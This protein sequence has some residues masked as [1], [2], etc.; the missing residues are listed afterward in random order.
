MAFYNISC[1]SKTHVPLVRNDVVASLAYLGKSDDLECKKYSIMTL[2]NLAANVETR[3]A[4]SRNGG[5]QTAIH[6]IKDADLDCRRYA[7]IALCN[8]ANNTTT[9]EQIVVHGALPGLLVM[10]QDASDIESQRQALLTISNLASNEMNHSSLMGKK[11][12]KV[13]TDAFESPDADVREYAAFAIANIAANPDYTALVG[14]N[15]GIPPL[16][17]LSKSASINTVCLG[18]AALRRMADS[19]E[20]WPKLIQAGMLDS[21]ANSGGST[22]LEIV[23]EVAAALCSLSLSHPHRV[24]IAYK[25]IR[26]MIQL[27]TSNNLDVARQSVGALANLAEDVDT[28]EYIARAGGSSCLVS[29]ERHESIDIHREA[30]RGIAN[31]LSSFRHQATIIEDGVPGLVR[32]AFS[33]DQ[34]CCYHSAMSFRKLAPNL[35]SHPVLVYA[36]TYKALFHLLTLPHQNTQRQAAAALRDLAANPEYKLRCAEDGG[37]PAMVDLV[38]QQADEEL[39][40]LGLAALRHISMEDSLKKMIVQERALRPSLKAIT[41]NNE[42]IQLQCA[43]LLANLSEL[44]ENQ[45]PM[46]E[47]SAVVGLVTLAFSKNPEIQQDTAR[48]L[49]NLASQQDAHV[50][51]YKQGA[52]T[53]LVKLSES[54]L[55]I[56]QRY[57]SIG[58][59]FLST[60]TEVISNLPIMLLYNISSQLHW[61]TGSSDACCSSEDGT[62]YLAK[63]VVFTGLPSYGSSIIR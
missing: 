38:R 10:A 1:A 23:R 39:Q 48:A 13:L 16:I 47:D 46:V 34:E 6:M 17:Q 60:D 57:A 24:E 51:M 3:A 43:G 12:M 63:R 49:A 55:D 41:S 54:D 11:I 37:I 20:N 22:E 5:L 58:I 36:G 44:A 30:S 62:I 40:A 61:T 25:C 7:C 35:K 19:E 28:H 53:S 56:T 50:P 31:L 32:L 26:C 29:L 18:L 14:R 33:A 42:D 27:S 8:M 4:A 59:R 52:F 15:G 21:L 45:I 2:A 9:Q